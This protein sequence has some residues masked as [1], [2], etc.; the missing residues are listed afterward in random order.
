VPA[1]RLIPS[2]LAA[3]LLPSAAA[4]QAGP[5]AWFQ[6]ELR[7]LVTAPGTWWVAGNT[8]HL[9][10]DEPFVKYAIR[11]DAED[12]GQSVSGRLVAVDSAGRVYPMWT[13]RMYWHPGERQPYL[14][15]TSSW[16]AY[17]VGPLRLDSSATRRAIVNEQDMWQP[18]GARSRTRHRSWFPDE[19][20]HVTVS[21]TWTNDAWVPGRTYRWVRQAFSPPSA[22]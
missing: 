21:S 13:Y 18:D 15:Q 22:G 6:A 20:T 11:W 19:S 7:Q 12:D 9:S 2:L 4:A 1:S 17:A 5:A 10:A 3:L 16:G 8:E 14:M